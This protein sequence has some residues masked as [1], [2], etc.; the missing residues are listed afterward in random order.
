MTGVIPSAE[1]FQFKKGGGF[2]CSASGI[3]HHE[4]YWEVNFPHPRQDSVQI[5]LHSVI[6]TDSK[7]IL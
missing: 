5:K 3:I 4:G 7:K 2:I 1:I 6:F